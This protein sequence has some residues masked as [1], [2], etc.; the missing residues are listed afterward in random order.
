[1]EPGDKI[2]GERIVC[3]FRKERNA[4]LVQLTGGH[5]G[6]LRVIEG[7]PAEAVIDKV[8]RLSA[9]AMKA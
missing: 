8:W 7:L 5:R 9:A 2:R 4:V 3:Q 1:M 6:M